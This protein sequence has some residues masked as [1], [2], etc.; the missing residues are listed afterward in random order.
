M[1]CCRVVI[2]VTGPLTRGKGVSFD[3]IDFMST[4][5]LLPVHFT[6][7]RRMLAG[8]FRGKPVLFFVHDA[9][10]S[11]KAGKFLVTAYIGS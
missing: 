2:R 5:E 11:I 9:H 8:P 10:G 4:R 7:D 3:S 1:R 6:L